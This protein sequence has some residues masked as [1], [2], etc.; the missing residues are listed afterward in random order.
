MPAVEALGLSLWGCEMVRHGK[1]T[2]LWVYVKGKEGGVTLDECAAVSRQISALFSVEHPTL[3]FN[4][5]QVSSPGLDRT[6][7]KPEQYQRYLGRELKVR[8][9]AAMDDRRNYKGILVASDDQGISLDCGQS[10]VVSIQFN[11]IEKAQLVP[12]F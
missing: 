2:E 10:E 8:T 6:F 12:Q 3:E 9:R 4:H 7:F 1:V 5:L 11:Q